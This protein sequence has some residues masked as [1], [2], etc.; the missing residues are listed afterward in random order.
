MR[1]MPRNRRQ[2][3]AQD[4]E[5][6]AMENNS[7]DHAVQ[8]LPFFSLPILD[9]YNIH[10]PICY[11]KS[12]EFL[13]LPCEHRFC[14]YCSSQYLLSLLG[15]CLVTSDMLVCPCCTTAID[16]PTIE[17]AIGPSE[18]AR[19]AQ[20]REK[21]TVERLVAANKAFYCPSE[22]C[23]GYAHTFE[24]SDVA[25]CTKCLT[26]MCKHCKLGAH[27]GL[28]CEEFDPSTDEMREL[29]AFLNSLQW[30]K[31]AYC[32]QGIEKVSGCQ[33]VRC[34]SPVCAST[35]NAICYLCGK[36]L[37]EKHHHSHYRSKG[38]YSNTCNGLEGIEDEAA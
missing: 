16:D 13:T 21:L 9:P 8:C 29:E 20:L 30:K 17:T 19:L 5:I 2:Q 33:F 15:S 25:T 34:K 10:C 32:G 4:L 6:L 38:P 18:F 14:L 28:P 3:V 22:S 12:L 31:C 27:P 24:V 23:S 11:S 35:D 1:R 7:W 26:T 36:G 37:K